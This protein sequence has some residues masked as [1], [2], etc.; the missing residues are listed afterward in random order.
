MSAQPLPLLLVEEDPLL[1]DLTAFRL[2]LLGYEVWAVH[3]AEAA[4]KALAE[5]LPAAVLVDLV[6]PDADGC[7]FV[8]R[9]ANDP[10]T[11]DIPTLVLSAD[12]D[13]NRV[14]KAFVA[15]ARDFLVTPYDPAVLQEKLSVLLD[16]AVV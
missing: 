6:L 14:E 8:S 7:E 2:E 15:G 10:R 16:A 9:L 4:H 11:A 13:L 3:S 1:A 12:A 5:R